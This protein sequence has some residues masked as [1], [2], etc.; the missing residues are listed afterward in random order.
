MKENHKKYTRDALNKKRRRKEIA[1]ERKYTAVRFQ[2]AI[3]SLDGNTNLPES[4]LA[5]PEKKQKTAL[6]QGWGF[7]LPNN[8]KF[9]P[10][11]QLNLPETKLKLGKRTRNKQPRAPRTPLTLDPQKSPCLLA[12]SFCYLFLPISRSLESSSARFLPDPTANEFF[13]Y[14][15]K[16]SE[17]KKIGVAFLRLLYN[18]QLHSSQEW[19][20]WGPPPDAWRHQ[21]ERCGA[22]RVSTR[23]WDEAREI[24]SAP[25]CPPVQAPRQLHSAP[26]RA[27]VVPHLRKHR[28]SSALITATRQCPTS[29]HHRNGDSVPVTL[30]LGRDMRQKGRRGLLIRPQLTNFAESVRWEI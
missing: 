26:P 19:G 14:R 28:Y 20:S 17:R 12:S 27:G 11:V 22:R 16:I 4:D 1:S 7:F 6:Q 15:P 5:F 30:R 8:K 29:S 3:F 13:L 10:S 18:K 21:A 9:R 2:S 25:R 24:R 23:G